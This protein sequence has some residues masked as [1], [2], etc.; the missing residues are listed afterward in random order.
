[1]AGATLVCLQETK[2]QEISAGDVA[3]ILGAEFSANFAFLPAIGTAGGILIA[4][5]ERF[6][7]FT[8]VA[9]SQNTV[10]VQVKMRDMVESWTCT[11]VYGPQS[12]QEKLNFIQELQNIKPIND[13]KWL[14]LG[15]F[16]IIMKA[17]DKNNGNYNRRVMGSFR[18]M[19]DRLELKEI[20][21][22]GRRFTW[23]NEREVVTLC[24]LDRIFCSVSWEAL[25]PV[26]T[27][28]TVSTMVSDHCPMLLVG[29]MKTRV[30]CSFRFESFWLKLPGLEQ[31]VSSAWERPVR[32]NDAM[33]KLHIKLSRTAKAIR[34][35]SNDRVGNTRVQ[36]AI[37]TEIIFRLDV[38][39][40]ERQLTSEEIIF[41]KELKARLLGLAAVE[42]AR[43]R[44]RSRQVWIR[45]GDA[46]TRFFHI[47]ASSRRRRNFIHIL[48]R[49][50]Q[51]FTTRKDKQQEVFRH[52]SSLLGEQAQGGTS[53]D[54]EGLGINGH[55]LS[56]L[57]VPFS[58][59]EIK[60][61]V[62]STHGEKAPGPD[63]F[64]G[65]FFKRFWEIIS[66][67]VIA[68]MQQVYELRGRRL[69]L[70]NTANIALL[71]KKADAVQVSDFRPISLIHSFAKLLAKILA[72][73]LASR[74]DSL[75]SRSQSA[76]I[77]RRCIQDNFMYTQNLTRILHRSKT[78]SLLLK[79]DIAKAF[80]SVKWG[81]ILELL[82]V[83]G[84]GPR[85]REWISMMWSSSSSRVI[86]NGETGD[87]FWHRKGLR[88]GD[89]ISP[90]L[91]IIAIDPL[92][93]LF[94]RATEAGILSPIR[95]SAAK[96]RVSLYADDAAIFIKPVQQELVAVQEIL[97][98]FGN[99]TGMITNI[100]KTEIFPIAC[101]GV[102]LE[103]LLGLLPGKLMSFPGKYLGLPLHL[104]RLRRAD[105]QFI[106]DMVGSR[107][108]GWKGRLIYRAGRLA[109]I[110][111]VLIPCLV[112][113]LSVFTPSKWLI[114]RI[115]KAIRSFLWKGAEDCKGG[116]CLVNWQRVCRP[117]SLG[118]LGIKNIEMFSSSLRLK[119]LWLEWMDH[120]KPWHGSILPLSA[121]ERSLFAAST[122]I[123]LGDGKTATFW[124]S[125]WLHG[126]APMEIAPG[127]FSKVRRKNIK[128]C[129]ALQGNKWI[130]SLRQVNCTEL[131]HE[132]VNLWM[133][134]REVQI[135]NMGQD[136]VS[137]RW[138][139]D[140]VYSA[141]S[142]YKAMFCGSFSGTCPQTFWKALA[143]NKV[144]IFCWL[145]SHGR[146]LTADRLIRRGWQGS[147]TCSMCGSH[148]ESAEHLLINCCFARQIWRKVA[149]WAG[150][151][152][153]APG[154]GLIEGTVY[155]WWLQLGCR[156]PNVNRRK[157]DGTV[158]YT[159][160]QIWKDRNGR[161][162]ENSYLG[163]H[164]T[165]FKIQEMIRTRELAFARVVQDDGG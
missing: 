130:K 58:A 52:F 60:A 40:E 61:A 83:L 96:L 64:T 135:P 113:F 76:F 37:A 98:V 70:L 144:K 82:Q 146:V 116:H 136:T 122:V 19:L 13:D 34:R 151:E 7:S 38:A 88:Q 48:R 86:L 107:A 36:M 1:M 120:S 154:D 110:N 80:D 157:F 59:E 39:Q 162:F 91:F 112:Y 25:F 73:R 47:K 102:D 104:R 56:D 121:S 155:S 160:W 87:R 161:V 125:R 69:G 137:W 84:F 68:A 105:T 71:P 66:A 45:E 117:K 23:S 139:A 114:A 94:D 140:G 62:F 27:L 89:P 21:L 106:L 108:A 142:V 133:L 18:A 123:T 46:N 111:A 26:C 67:D 126:Q 77:K 143:E 134:I 3:Q 51:V 141:S 103:A 5:T 118:G 14:L 28:H 53:L 31:V 11:G 74:L 50:R 109:L 65:E 79:L 29:E 131:V 8:G 90:M 124:C 147:V 17:Q 138:T 145:L 54:W 150:F 10:S 127:L 32:G 15:D 22:N 132:F 44:Q 9:H 24:K 99:A 57:E 20:K 81:Y 128:V 33:R 115:N 75:V 92:Q 163:V 6:F 100:S 158:A 43:M 72:N 159:L 42:R 148:Q 30:N 164:D 16:N 93:R 63:G 12:D 35:W 149:T 4:G 49:D 78:P 101:D 41:R 85:W 156:I 129:S 152:C 97:Q 95:S 2:L 55:D 119:W 165:V 153:L